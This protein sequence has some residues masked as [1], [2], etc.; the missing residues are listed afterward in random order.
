MLGRVDLLILDDWPRAARHR[1]LPRPPGDPRGPL[2]PPRHYRRQPAPRRSMAGADRRPTYADDVLDRL[3]HNAHRIDLD[4]E[5]LANPQ[6]GSKDLSQW[7]CV[8]AASLGQ[9]EGRCPHAKKSFELRLKIDHTGSPMPETKQPEGLGPR[10]ISS[11]NSGRDHLGILGGIKSVHLGK[12]IEILTHG[13][14]ADGVNGSKYG[15]YL[16]V[17][18]Q[19]R[20]AVNDLCDVPSGNMGTKQVR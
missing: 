5:S 17:R 11:R 14:V 2:R 13:S 6:A 1:G 9:G 10:A 3:V 15:S 19:K 7:R 12:I 8:H 16:R 4:G 20:R 18:P